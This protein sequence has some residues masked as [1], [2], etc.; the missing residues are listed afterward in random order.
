MGYGN[1]TGVLATIIPES[2]SN[3]FRNDGKL[4]ARSVNTDHNEDLVN[5]FKPPT[6]PRNGDL[7]WGA[8]SAPA[9]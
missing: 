5:V 7:S 8:D 9:L 6:S 1:N 2:I 4:S 3:G